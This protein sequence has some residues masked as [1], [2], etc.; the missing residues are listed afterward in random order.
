[1][2]KALNENPVVQAV[3]IGLMA[4]IVA[5]LLF[6]RVLNSGG[7]TAPAPPTATDSAEVT[8]PAPATDASAAGETTTPAPS[9]SPAP[10]DST[11]PPTGTAPVPGAA[12]APVEDA[13]EPGPGLPKPVVSA[14]D[15]GNTVML[16]IEK[17]KG[18][19][20]RAL[21][22]SAALVR[23]RADTSLFLVPA[24]KVAKFARITEGVQLSRTPAIVVL[25]PK[26]L[27]KG[28]PE[29]TV[30]YGFRGPESV[31]QALDDALYKGESV[32]YD[33]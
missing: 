20:D 23:A 8:T 19:D 22:G 14:Y 29:A 18:L 24:A 27:T 28:M 32:T 1:M 30:S 31:E 17:Q 21:L 2:R 4:L 26:R 15:A 33:P 6:T 16:L 12:P 10:A 3:V 25:R 9:A 7:E 11:A 13:F 5:F